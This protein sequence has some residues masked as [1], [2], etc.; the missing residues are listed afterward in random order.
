MAWGRLLLLVTSILV[1][2]ALSARARAGDEAVPTT[3]EGGAGQ[4]KQGGQEVGEGFRGVGRGIKKT[5]TG[6]RS[7]EDYEE[8]SKIG[9]GFADMGKGVAG[10][11]RG[12]GRDVKKGF[13]TDGEPAEE[14]EDEQPAQAE[15]E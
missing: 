5:F 12:V 14:E 2:L 8:G 13:T 4:I 10:V 6:E 7:K 1:G 15:D 9:T 3:V 11:G